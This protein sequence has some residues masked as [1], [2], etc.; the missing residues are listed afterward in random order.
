MGRAR[1]AYALSDDAGAP[2]ALAERR[3]VARER[4]RTLRRWEREHWTDIGEQASAAARMG[5]QLELFRLFVELKSRRHDRRGSSVKHFARIFGAIGAVADHVWQ[6]AP[7]ASTAERR[8][9]K[10]PNDIESDQCA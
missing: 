6:N 7:L 1:V 10:P 5:D 8:L 9:A 4:R 2:A 3:R